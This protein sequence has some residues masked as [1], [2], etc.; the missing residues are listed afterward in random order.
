LPY[1]YEA[2][3]KKLR[4]VS[5]TG[6]TTEYIDGIQY[7]GTA[8]DFIQTETGRIRKAGSAYHYEYTIAD[9]LGNARLSFDINGGAARRIQQDDYYPFGLTFG[10]YVL[11]TKNKYL[12]NGKEEQEEL[13]MYD[14]GARMYDPVVGRW[15]VPDPLSELGR[16]WSPYNY[17]WNNPLLF[18]DPDGMF[19]TPPGD[20]YDQ[21]GK[22][23]GT[24]GIDDDKIYVVT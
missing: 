15:S 10:S 2:S 11:G 4:K 3:G 5:S 17:A 1:T 9:H 20:F 7:T 6:G 24:D 18:I 19:A 23:L 14:Y 16:R 8:L 13:N 22:Y 12:Y 21:R